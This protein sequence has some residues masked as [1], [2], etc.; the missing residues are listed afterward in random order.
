MKKTFFLILFVS[1]VFLS[2]A[3]VN[4]F[5]EKLPR[6]IDNGNYFT[7]EEERLLEERAK[8][9]IEKFNFDIVLVTENELDDIAVYADDFYD[10]NGYGYGENHDGLLFITSNNHTKS[11]VST[12]GYGIKVFTDDNISQIGKKVKSL[13]TPDTEYEAYMK[14]LDISED[15][16]EQAKNNVYSGKEITFSECVILIIV[17]FAVS[18]LVCFVLLKMNN[19]NVRATNATAYIKGNGANITNSQDIFL[20][21]TQTKRAKESSSNKSSTHSS[22]SGRSHGGGGW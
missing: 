1:I 7:D 18:L 20:F 17:G 13:R 4:A 16:L 12:C 11:W 21:R 22:S 19:T 6:I 9:I 8:E 5:D 10:Y 2:V 14:F 15:F 3:S